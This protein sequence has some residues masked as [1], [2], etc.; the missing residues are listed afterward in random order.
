MIHIVF[1]G[2]PHRGRS[3]EQFNALCDALHHL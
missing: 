3:G 1:T 2:P